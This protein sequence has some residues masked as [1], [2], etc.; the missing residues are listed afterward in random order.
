MIA[1][2]PAVPLYWTEFSN[3]SRIVTW[4]TAH[5]GKISTILKGDQR[6]NSPFRGQY[7]LFATSELLFYDRTERGTLIAKECAMITPRTAF[8]AD[9][10]ACAA[11]GCLS[12]LFA[13]TTPRHG[14]EPGRFAFFEDLLSLA[15][16]YGSRRAFLPWAEL[17]FAAFHGHA[18]ALTDAGDDPPRFS[19]EHGG[20]IS[21]AYARAHRIPATPFPADVL[22]ILR[23]WQRA[24][25]P[26]TAL[27]VP[28]TAAQMAQADRLMQSF[29]GYHFDMPPHIRQTAVEIIRAA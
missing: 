21:A 18:V 25:A 1:K 2:T 14:H 19:A 27:A 7:D 28:C 3:T 13:K 17:R 10:R 11:A 26:E 9:W 24:D 8:R 4:Y 29:T 20:V 5:Y 22:P 16:E 12:A 15:A 6:K 23:A